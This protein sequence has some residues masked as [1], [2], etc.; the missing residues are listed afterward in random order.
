M[1]PGR[2]QDFGAQVAHNQRVAVLHP[3]VHEGSRAPLVHHHRYAEL[4]GERVRGREMIG[5]G[6]GVEDVA[7]AQSFFRG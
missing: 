7:N 4:H 6:V 3:K 5:V 2:I 1:C